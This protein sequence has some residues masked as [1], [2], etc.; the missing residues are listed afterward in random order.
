MRDPVRKRRRERAKRGEPIGEPVGE[1]QGRQEVGFR[2]LAFARAHGHRVDPAEKFVRGYG[3]LDRFHGDFPVV[4]RTIWRRIVNI[5]KRHANS[6]SSFRMA[7]ITAANHVHLFVSSR[8]LT[9]LLHLEMPG[10]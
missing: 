4:G 8:Y 7:C 9:R 3:V 5:G 2:A 6:Q 1:V 10:L